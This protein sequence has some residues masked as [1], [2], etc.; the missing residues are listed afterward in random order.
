L[1]QGVKFPV[2]QKGASAG[3]LR[4][5]ALTI[6]LLG[7]PEFGLVGI[8][9]PENYVHPSALAAFADMIREASENVQLLLTTR[10]PLFL[11]YLDTPDAVCVVRRGAQGTYVE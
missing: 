6:A 2:D 4:M 9:E 7:E 3:T 1:E 5:L 10:S 11:N 8:Q